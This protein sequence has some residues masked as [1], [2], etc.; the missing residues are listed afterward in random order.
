MKS[1]FIMTCLLIGLVCCNNKAK[2]QQ[3][4]V[5]Q[6]AEEYA[7][8]R[9][10]DPDSYEFAVLQLID[11]TLYRDNIKYR[12]DYFA[13]DLD[14]DKG[15]LKRQLENKREFPSLYDKKAVAELREKIK[16]NEQ[17]ILEI[18]QLEKKLAGQANNVA[19]Y[20]YIFTFRGKN[21]MGAKVLNEYILQTDPSP[22]YN[23]INMTSDDDKVFLN[24]NEFP[25]YREMI[26]KYL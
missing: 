5:K 6:K 13:R 15:D 21:A 9:M 22:N 25:G 19:A 1:L 26:T 24:P 7:K 8:S 11:S 18:D 2:N 12:R 16:R 4:I 3:D 17:I 23:V 14:N 20:K 10:N